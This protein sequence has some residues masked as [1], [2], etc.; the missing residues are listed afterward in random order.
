LRL[1]LDESLL[2]H[3]D[4]LGTHFYY[5][6]VITAYLAADLGSLPYTD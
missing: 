5:E 2:D 6:G 1:L 3:N 4:S